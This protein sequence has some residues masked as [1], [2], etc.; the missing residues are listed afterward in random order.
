MKRITPKQL[1]AQKLQ[2]FGKFDSL[3]QNPSPQGYPQKLKIR[4][5]SLEIFE[6]QVGRVSRDESLELRPW[7]PLEP[8]WRY[9]GPESIFEGLGLLSDLLTHSKVSHQMNVVNSEMTE[10]LLSF[11]L[12]V[13]VWVSKI[14]FVSNQKKKKKK[15][16]WRST[17]FNK[18][19]STLTYSWQ[20]GK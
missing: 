11:R 7:E 9:Y 10:K 13:L 20:S 6:V 5:N 12:W 2:L 16:T 14:M 18:H 17:H 8:L 3:F 1:K 4:L 15:H 19:S